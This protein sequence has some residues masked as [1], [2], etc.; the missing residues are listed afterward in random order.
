MVTNRQFGI[1]PQ[2]FTLIEVLL[3]VVILGIAAVITVPMIAG[4]SDLQAT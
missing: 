2:A 3:V 4:T 1:S